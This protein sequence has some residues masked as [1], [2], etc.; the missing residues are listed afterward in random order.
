MNQRPPP[1][2][3]DVRSPRDPQGR[4]S[5]AEEARARGHAVVIRLSDVRARLNDPGDQTSLDDAIERIGLYQDLVDSL[6]EENA[7][8]RRRLQQVVDTLTDIQLQQA[9]AIAGTARLVKIAQ[10]VV[11]N[12]VSDHVGARLGGATG[13]TRH[14][15]RGAEPF[16]PPSAGRPDVQESTVPFPGVRRGTMDPKR[17][18]QPNPAFETFLDEFL[19]RE[20]ANHPAQERFREFA[21][22][23][24]YPGYDWEGD[25]EDLD[26][27]E[28][29]KVM[30]AVGEFRKR[31]SP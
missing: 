12:S 22:T 16:S 7:L 24:F 3:R 6:D 28:L 27:D 21:R 26:N 20:F 8:L 29:I 11:K 15:S 31:T 18:H 5:L 23:S 13:E 2:P 10:S 14:E 4:N 30:R 19:A 25:V 9:E 1:E 17:E